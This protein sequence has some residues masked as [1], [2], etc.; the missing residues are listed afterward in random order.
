[1][2]SHSSSSDEFW[3]FMSTSLN[4]WSSLKINLF[5]G[6]WWDN[7]SSN[8]ISSSRSLF[9][10]PYFLFENWL[11][12]LI[13]GDLLAEAKGLFDI[14][15]LDWKA[16]LANSWGSII[17]FHSSINCWHVFIGSGVLD[18]LY[19]DAGGCTSFIKSYL[20]KLLLSP[21]FGICGLTPLRRLSYFPGLF[22]SMTV[23]IGCI[24]API[25]ALFTETDFFEA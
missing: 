19:A 23:L 14:F 10:F 4:V 21:W 9:N 24:V 11:K 12:I 6:F 2:S 16:L 8:F 25:P 17:D 1:M 13:A 3:L 5:W 15:L 18:P 7:S 20:A 22:L